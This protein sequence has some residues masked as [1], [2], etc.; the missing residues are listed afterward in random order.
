MKRTGAGRLIAITLAAALCAAL[1]APEAYAAKPAAQFD[2]NVAVRWFNLLHDLIKVERLT[3]PVA[4]RTIG[5]AGVTIYEA[6]AL[7]MPDHRS[8]AGQLNELDA[9]PASRQG[10]N[11][12]WPAVA[13][14][15]LARSLKSLFAGAS[16]DSLARIDALEQEL[17]AGMQA[18]VKQ[19]LLASST[20]QGRAVADAIIA[21]AGGD[22]Y[23]TLTNCPYTPP[24]G[25][26][27]WE[28]TPPGFRPALQPCWG[29]LRPFVL[30][31]GGEC[32]PPPHPAYSTDPASDF[33]AEGFEVYDTVNHLSQQQ[34]DI[35]LFWSDDPGPA[36]TPPG[37]W[38]SIV[39]Q[40]A[41]RDHLSLD[42]A[43]EAYA[44]VGL[45]VADAFITCWATKFQDNL[46]RPITY[47]RNLLDPAW[48][49]PLTTPA[50][51][52]FTSG[53]ST[54]SAAASELLT[55]LLG[56]VAF[57]DHTHDARGL[58]PRVF[59]SF[60]AAAEEAAISRLYGGIHYQAAIELG[61][62]QGRCVAG[63]VRERV[64]FLKDEDEDEEDE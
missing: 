33:Y 8:L 61:L 16:S 31:S 12:H 27:L 23:S 46:L 7:G 57:V 39:S 3:P 11:F 52:E 17:A 54:Q 6:I 45:G 28:P 34:T 10:R 38:I 36:G 62:G 48:N 18:T 15:A 41:V 5:Y 55:D 25:A 50:F 1:A 43:A 40:I 24:V 51:P 20:A 29:Q 64:R 13:N 2:S 21:W 26:G 60:T 37:H 53:H 35:A 44:R 14:A 32:A 58:A 59:G 19:K 9:I 30:T 49:S 47:I 22:G 56:D 63:A 42:R 4:S